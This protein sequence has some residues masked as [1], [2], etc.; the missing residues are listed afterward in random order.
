M[1]E[2]LQPKQYERKYGRFLLK[3]VKEVEAEFNEKLAEIIENDNPN[4]TEELTALLAALLLWWQTKRETVLF[5]IRF[6]FNAINIYNDD[7]FKMV[8]KDISKLIIPNSVY[9]PFAVENLTSP[10]QDIIRV[11]GEGTDVYRY[12]PYLPEIENNWLQ[13]QQEY[14]D[15]LIN[16]ALSDSIVV[17]RN[18]IINALPVVAMN[19]TIAAIFNTAEKRAVR[20]TEQQ[21]NGLDTLLM[22]KRQVSFNADTYE[23]ETRRDERV[24]GTPGGLYPRA[25]PSHYARDRQI[26]SWDNPPEGGH[27]GD[28]EGC[29]CKPKMRLPL[30]K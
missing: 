28:A 30:L 18:N 4:K 3:T 1:K 16:K 9:R 5:T 21:T 11:F 10:S 2:W 23:W 15:T 27:P 13:T 26:F 7:Q 17:A 6:L 24:R 22:K 19:A 14:A 20:F 8:V 25:R 29:R 12:E